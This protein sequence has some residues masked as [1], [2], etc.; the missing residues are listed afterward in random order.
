MQSLINVSL[1]LFHLSLLTLCL[2]H[3]MTAHT[4]LF[5][6]GSINLRQQHM[7][8]NL[9]GKCGPPVKDSRD[10]AWIGAQDLKV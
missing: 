2:R 5:M 9:S 10:P 1:L 8:M 6:I 7:Q 3:I 4:R